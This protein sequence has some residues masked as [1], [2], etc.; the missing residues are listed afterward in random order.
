MN[1]LLSFVTGP[2][3][4]NAL[5]ATYDFGLVALS[6]L[7]AS[8]AAYTA[9]DLGGRVSEFRSEPRRAA[10]WLAGGAF[11]MGAGIWAMH[12]VAMLAYQLPIP[13]RYEVWITL[14]SMLPAIMA[15]GLA[16]YVVTRGTLSWARLLISGTLMG[17]GIGVMHYSGMAAMR[18]DALVMYFIGP[19]L[20]SIVN[21]VVCSTIAL[22]LV[23]RVGST[24]LPSKVM[25]ALVMGVAIAGMHYTGMYAAVCVSTGHTAAST[26]GLDPVPLAAAIAA[27]TLLIMSMALTVSLQSQLLS[28]RLREQN[29]LLTREVQQRRGAEAELQ[30]HRDNLQMLVNERTQA[31][32][33]A[34]LELRES[35]ARFRS[36]TEM[37]ADWYWEQDEELRFTFQSSGFD[38]SS[39]TT[40]GQILGKRRWEEPNRVPLSGTWE[41][42]RATLAARK[43]FRDFEFYR[44]S[45]DGMRHFI[46]L[47]GE[48]VHDGTGKF[49]GYRGIGRNIS[50]AKRAEQQLQAAKEAAEAA[51]RTKSEFLATMSHE[52]RTPMNGVLGMTELL[53][54][55]ELGMRQRKFAEA[56]HRSSVALLSIINDILDLSK[57]EAGKLE[58]QTDTFDLRELV[59]DVA[60]TVA[61]VARGKKLE[62]N[63]MIPSSVPTRVV[64]SSARLRQVL[65]NLAGNAIKFTEHGAVTVS[66]AALEENAD[67]VLLRFDV[68]DAGIGIAADQL[69]RIFGSFTQVQSDAHRKYGGTGLGL[70]ISKQLVEKMGGEI[71]V[72]SAPGAG[73]TFWFKL[74][75]AKQTGESAAA[76]AEAHRAMLGLRVM[77]VDHN[78]IN[79]LIIR[80]QL[81]SAGV[82]HDEADA[83]TRALAKMRGASERGE[84]FDLVITE[85]DMPYMDGT[86]LARAIRADPLLAAI[87]LIM[88]S[89]ASRDE[90]AAH[91]AGIAYCLTRPVRQSHLYDCLVSTL[92]RKEPATAAPHSPPAPPKLQARLLLVEDHPV[93]REL[94]L[95]ILQQLGCRVEMAENGHGALEAFERI[96]FDLI[97]MDCQM[98]GMDGYEATAEIRRREAARGHGSRVPIIALTAG[99]VEGDREKCLAA[100]MDDYVTKP[101][102]A[103]EL[104][105]ALRRWLPA[106]DKGKD[107]R[108]LRMNMQVIE[109][110]RALV[111]DGEGLV[112][113]LVRVYLGDAPARLQSLREA[114][115]RG[116]T[117]AT[118][119]IAHAFK[120]ASSNLGAE[121]LADLCRQMEGLSDADSARAR[122][123]LV[124][125]EAEFLAVATALSTLSPGARS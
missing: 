31:L 14:A 51:S 3:P 37:S 71:G 86:A 13:V 100:G 39:G 117:V 119:S 96:G 82:I 105:S 38:K 63:C 76:V 109:R 24:G 102:F 68:K 27:V 111:S 77:I 45:E 107:A 84:P 41:D 29:D 123:L 46:S 108:A 11:A 106:P 56:A 93:N 124:E 125:V 1:D 118:R 70:S 30:G 6:Y 97:L 2:L 88:V 53:L 72:T 85:D 52:I 116:D 92:V 4:G 62:F 94:A 55:T 73:S 26:T 57:I 61:E 10:G 74:R 23:F 42:H 83:G 20:L 75:L 33:H 115:L 15:A 40:T 59:E 44:D 101:Y 16:L 104:E 78:A 9:I 113:K 81:D 43:P 122:P 19:W 121:A 120:S 66:V 95:A 17:A 89:S 49:I 60:E 25:A 34:N 103:K 98:P 22:W 47:S 8:L 36:L 12:F 79:R 58:I 87:P 65:I 114:V 50:E 67:S 21:A 80:Q 54:G 48:P 64:G 28:R 91:D 32:S 90:S 112:G 99:V 18:M 69:D 35:E 7:V 5:S 110:I